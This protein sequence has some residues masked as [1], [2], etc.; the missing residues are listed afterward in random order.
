M[1]GELDF[2]VAGVGGQGTVLAS[3]I[4]AEVGAAAGYE[5]KKSD[6]LGL[7]VRGGSVLS[8]V[9]WGNEVASPVGRLGGMDFL[10]AFE[11]LEALRGAAFLTPGGVA[12]INDQPVP[13]VSVSSGTATYPSWEEI[14]RVLSGAAREVHVVRASEA[15]RRLGVVRA[16]NVVLLGAFSTL[17]EVPQDAWESV[18]RARVPAKYAEANLN[19]FRVGRGLMDRGSP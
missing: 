12:L 2:L 5:V 6:V 16:G 17:L 10:V 3:D 18:V 4:L 14:R 1:K 9:R 15:A 7:A 8:H 19:A 13:P 11:P